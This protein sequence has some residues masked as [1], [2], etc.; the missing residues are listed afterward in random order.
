ML[1]RTAAASPIL[2]LVYD[3]RVAR[4]ARCEVVLRWIRQMFSAESNPWFQ[5]E[6][7]HPDDFGGA[8][9]SGTLSFD[10]RD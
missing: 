10:L 9:P 4:V 8:L 6:F 1:G 2:Y 5:P 3:P 7:V